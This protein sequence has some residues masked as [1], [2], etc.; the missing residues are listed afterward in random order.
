MLS[1]F[2]GFDI[3]VAIFILVFCLVGFKT[4]IVST[5]FY[6]SSGYIGLFVASKY[7]AVLKMNFYLVFFLVA[8][9]TIIAGLIVGQM[10]REA[11]L[12]AADNI[13]GLV[14]GGI[15]GIM[16][17]SILMFPVLNKLSWENQV[18][19]VSSYSGS[20]VIP[21]VQ[22]ML[23]PMKELSFKRVREIIEEQKR[24]ADKFKDNV[25]KESNRR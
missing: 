18:Y 21:W 11:V 2:N 24:I 25:E 16:F 3:I 1:V 14:F 23:P 20:H 17:I 5:L 8:L 19:V 9:A 4:G 12:G 15:F 6:I 22:K 7:S 10:V 13:F